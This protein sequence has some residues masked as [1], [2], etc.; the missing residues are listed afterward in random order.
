M[1]KAQSNA[2]GERSGYEADVGE[3]CYQPIVWGARA[4]EKSEETEFGEAIYSAQAPTPKDGH[5]TGYYIELIFPGDTEPTTRVLK[6]E[7]IYSTPGFTFPDTL[8]FADCTGE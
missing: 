4:I 8:P 5:W 2:Y 3:L 6:S 7:Y 1:S